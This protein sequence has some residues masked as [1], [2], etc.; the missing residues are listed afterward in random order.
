MSSN[1]NLITGSIGTRKAKEVKGAQEHLPN[2][3]VTTDV[4]LDED[5]PAVLVTV[6]FPLNYDQRLAYMAKKTLVLGEN[7]D[8]V[9]ISFKQQKTNAA[10]EPIFLDAAGNETTTETATPALEDTVLT[11][12]DQ[13]F[14][15]NCR[16]GV[17]IEDKKA[18]E[19]AEAEADGKD[20]PDTE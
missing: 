8:P 12:G 18:A 4:R 10:N 17:R 14:F 15:F 3:I 20:V 11:M 5:N 7:L 19:T 13:P 9:S 6:E 1:E 16:L 2:A